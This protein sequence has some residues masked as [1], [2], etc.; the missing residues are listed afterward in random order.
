MAEAQNK[1]T[2]VPTFIILH[3][4]YKGFLIFPESD[5][6]IVALQLLDHLATVQT[7]DMTFLLIHIPDTN[8]GKCITWRYASDMMT[9]N[10][11]VRHVLTISCHFWYSKTSISDKSPSINLT[12]RAKDIKMIVHV[13]KLTHAATCSN[14]MQ[15]L[16]NNPEHFFLNGTCYYL[17][18]DMVRVILSLY[19]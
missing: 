16:H 6:F 4:R 9:T 19:L 1:V 11:S 7:A 8:L 3:T 13:L 14:E 10:H 15:I 18:N 5:S 12:P 17:L 2:A